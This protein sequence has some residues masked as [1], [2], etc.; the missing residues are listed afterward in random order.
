MTD[1]VLPHGRSTGSSR[2]KVWAGALAA[3]AIAMLLLWM[4]GVLTPG[5]I[6]P[7]TV[8][9]NSAVDVQGPTARVEAQDVAIWRECAGTV[10]PRVAAA[11]ASKLMANVLEVRVSAG[12]TVRKGDLLIRLDGRDLEA[13]QR[14]A[15]A[16][17]AAARAE[18]ADA[19]ADQRRFSLL[20][21]RGSVT[22]R[23]Y[24]GVNARHAM[25]EARVKAAEQAVIQ[26]GVAR[27]YVEITAPI[28]GVVAEKL[29]DPGD[30]AVPGKPLLV[31]HDPRQLR[32]EAWVPEEM[33]P[34]LAV[35]N[36]VTVHVDAVAKTFS[37]RI[38]EIVPQADPATRTIAVRVAL[39]A[40]EG[41]RSG[42]FG[43]LSVQAG[44]V[45]ILSIPRRAVRRV[46]QL[47]SV[48]V[49]TPAGMRS[50]HVQ[51]GVVRGDQVEVLAGLEAGETI[52]LPLEESHE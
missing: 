36:P 50:R 40:D 10:A 6:P 34:R 33:A 15:E 7:G 51:T 14:E 1:A 48:E 24:D 21:E 12:A 31:L 29:V 22:Q 47:E 11:V 45:R 17:L 20:I 28:D 25:A 46:G 26:A 8:A 13:R 16:S 52:V 37:A 43:R 27:G 49:K 9:A 2:A 38:D 18:L 44:S 19:A 32:V 23:E 35:G 30:L 42:M 3:A 39:P 5:K 4:G 41:L